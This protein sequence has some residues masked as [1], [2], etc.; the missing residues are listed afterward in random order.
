MKQDLKKLH[1]NRYSPYIRTI[2]KE[3]GIIS[4]NKKNSD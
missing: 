2:H 1:I 3:E 4:D